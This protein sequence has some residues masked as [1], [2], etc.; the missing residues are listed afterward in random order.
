MSIYKSHFFHSHLRDFTIAFGT[1][2]NHIKTAKYKESGGVSEYSTVPLSYTNKQSWYVKLKQDRDNERKPAIVLPRMAFSM[3]GMEYDP[4]RKL[5]SKHKIRQIENNE[6]RYTY[7]PVPYNV[8]F[9]LLVTTKNQTEAQQ[10]VEQI[11]PFFTPDYT[12]TIKSIKDPN[13]NIDVPITID[14]ITP[15]INYEGEF[16]ERQS[17]VWELNFTMKTYLFGPIRS[18]SIIRKAKTPI[19]SSMDSD[20]GEPLVDMTIQP[21]IEGVPLSEI[22]ESDN[23]EIQKII[24]EGY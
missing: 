3:T 7:N 21:Y 19:F 14:G 20:D 10:I 22:S 18:G 5:N 24:D 6:S 15:D 12:I 4:S 8:S 13:V 16:T 17:I 11:V 9:T 1:L 23:Y 2:F